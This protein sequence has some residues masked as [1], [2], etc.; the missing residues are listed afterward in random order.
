MNPK[1][2]KSPDGSVASWLGHDRST[3]LSVMRADT[4]LQ[5]APLGWQVEGWLWGP[6]FSSNPDFL[7]WEAHCSLAVSVPQPGLPWPL[8]YTRGK[9]HSND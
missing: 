6:T 4:E 3:L 5:I 8:K 2:T 7:L 9:S 1:E